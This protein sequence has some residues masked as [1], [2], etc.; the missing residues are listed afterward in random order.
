MIGLIGGTGLLN[1]QGIEI[2]QQENFNTPYGKAS[3]SFCLAKVENQT[4]IFIPRHGA[5][6]SIPPH[7]INYRANMWGLKKLGVT[8]VL[9]IATVGGISKNSQ[10]NTIVIPDQILD[11]TYGRE[12]TIFDGQSHPVE[13]IDFTLPYD[14]ILRDKVITYAKKVD[15]KCHPQGTYAAAQGPRLETAAEINRYE[16]DGATIVGMTGMPEA[17]LAK[18]LGLAYT[19]ICPV[20]NCAAGRGDSQQG[21]SH[22]IIT[23]NSEKLMT[24]LLSFVLGFIKEYGD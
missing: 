18:E 19:A 17:S 4:F 3:D 16:K 15:F 5:N 13:H 1:F 11:Y 23:K 2:I 6:H 21:L 9:A 8:D 22:E 20:V 7:L 24:Q 12:H 14:L 10:P